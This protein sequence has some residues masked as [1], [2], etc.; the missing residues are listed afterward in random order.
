MN[1]KLAIIAVIAIVAVAGAFY[2]GMKYGQSQSRTSI[3]ARFGEQAGARAGGRGGAGGA[4]F[5]TGDIIAK[6]DKSITVKLRD[7]GS[8]IIFFAPST[9]V[10]KFAAGALA[11]LAVGTSIMANGTANSDGSIT[12]KTIQVR[13]ALPAGTTPA[14]K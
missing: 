5:A 9:E 2:G 1:K 12:A 10:S 6:D 7:G 3:G 14:T 8:K 13:P 4:G 11:D